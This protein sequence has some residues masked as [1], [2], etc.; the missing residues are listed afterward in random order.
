MRGG[1]G[2][3][4]DPSTYP[5]PATPDGADSAN[6]V[7]APGEFSWP[8]A[9]RH[10]RGPTARSPVA[11]YLILG[12]SGVA[13]TVLTLWVRNQGAV[14]GLDAQLHEWVL[15]HRGS[16][17]TALARVVTQGGVT[18]LALPAL[19]VIGA[20]A[21]PGH[22]SL[23]HRFGSG[24]LLAGLASAGVY[25]GLVLN[26]SV[27]RVRPPPIDWAGPAGG[28]SYPSGHTTVATLFALSCAWAFADRLRSRRSR[29]ALWVAAVG[30]AAAV[31][32]SRI[33]LGV[34]W[35]TDVIGGWLYATAWFALTTAAIIGLRNASTRRRSSPVIDRTGLPARRS[36]PAR[37]STFAIRTR[38]RTSRW[39]SPPPD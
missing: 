16:P 35:P 12:L 34:H 3:F 20:L 23:R 30:Y 18:N 14:P 5:V 17:D 39:T 10:D 15:A 29:I 22:R 7:S 27:G 21:P 37:R 11:R 4:E 38:S 28:P 19:L 31:G 13:C 2:G 24:L 9:G 6:A 26:A 8:P 33:W 25:L 36:W 32:C 1:P